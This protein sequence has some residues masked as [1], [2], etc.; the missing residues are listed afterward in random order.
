LQYDDHFDVRVIQ[1]EGRFVV[2]TKFS[3][4][5]LD[6]AER[7]P[8]IRR[9]AYR[10]SLAMGDK[11]LHVEITSE[12]DWRIPIL[13]MWHAEAADS[14]QYRWALSDLK[15]ALTSDQEKE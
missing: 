3:H 1:I 14:K 2:G 13:E 10:V 7:P 15:A 8:R 5:P 11:K 12:I 6:P 9:I 4:V